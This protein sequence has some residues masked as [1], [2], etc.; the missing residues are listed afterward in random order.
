MRR[1]VFIECTW[2]LT[3]LYSKNLDFI[4]T[5][6]KT[7]CSLPRLVRSKKVVSN[8]IKG[9]HSK[10]LLFSHR[11]L[12]F[13]YNLNLD[14]S[15]PMPPN[16]MP[17]AMSL[18]KMSM[19]SDVR[20]ERYTG[21]VAFSNFPIHTCCILWRLLNLCFV[22]NH[23]LYIRACMFEVTDLSGIFSVLW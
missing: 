13:A 22:T 11:C 12:I 21:N 18:K 15:A 20:F 1:Q 3:F 8:N 16:S 5:F 17:L 23:M 9:M 4:H 14:F 7:L 19:N 6:S 10:S 2:K